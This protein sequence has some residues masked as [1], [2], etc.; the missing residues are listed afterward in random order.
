MNFKSIFTHLDEFYYSIS[1]SI[2]SAFCRAVGRLVLVLRVEY[3][4]LEH[5]LSILLFELERESM[6]R[7]MRHLKPK[8]VDR[9]I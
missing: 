1:E 4:S 2:C 9:T 3:I 7:T 8:T 6:L 5:V